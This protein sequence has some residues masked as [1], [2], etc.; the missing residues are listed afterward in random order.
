[1][2]TRA[3]AVI[4][5]GALINVSAIKQAQQNALQA[6]TEAVRTDFQ[7]TTQTWNHQVNF[8]IQVGKT[9]ASVW[10]DDEVYMWVNNGTRPHVIRPRRAAML[11]F[12][13]PF[14]A[15]TVVGAIRSRKGSKGRK[16]VF[17]KQVMHPGTT[18]RGF[19]S[20]IQEKWE[21]EW[22]KMLQQAIDSAI[23]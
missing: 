10:T 5:K 13:Q 12:T 9:K 2:P 15:K 8:R 3:K 22:P 6:A 21:T 19:D 1:M 20:V 18:A 7:V 14:R 4:P 17:A 16:R 23:G 11:V